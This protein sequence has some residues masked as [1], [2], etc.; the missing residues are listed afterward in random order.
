MY[1]RNWDHSVKKNMT[2]QREGWLLQTVLL[3]R[4]RTRSGLTKG[5]LDRGTPEHVSALKALSTIP[6][7]R[8]SSELIRFRRFSK[9]KEH[10]S[11]STYTRGRH[12]YTQPVMLTHYS[13]AE[14]LTP[15]C[16]AWSCHKQNQTR[17]SF[18]WTVKITNL[19]DL[20]AWCSR[21]LFCVSTRQLSSVWGSLISGR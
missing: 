3:W 19:P 10:F 6:Q 18:S 1:N 11:F 4:R 5:T 21:S 9:E 17:C 20:R 13:P 8:G 12:K 15:I 2:T 14:R 7:G 16:H